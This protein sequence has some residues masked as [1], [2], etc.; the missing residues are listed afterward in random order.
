MS[1]VHISRQGF[2]TKTALPSVTR[3]RGPVPVTAGSTFVLTG[4]G[5]NGD[6]DIAPILDWSGQSQ[7]LFKGEVAH[8]V[9]FGPFTNDSG[10]SIQLNGFSHMSLPGPQ[11]LAFGTGDFTIEFFTRSKD[12]TKTTT[13]ALIYKVG[14]APSAN[15][16]DIRVQSNTIRAVLG[17]TDPAITGAT[18][19]NNIWY[20]IALVRIAGSTKLYVNGTQSGSTVADTRNYLVPDINSTGPMPLLFTD[21]NCQFS[22]NG[23]NAL[24]GWI[25]NFRIVKGTGVYSGNFSK[26]IANL[27]NTGA[28]SA[29]SYSSTT[30]V[31]ITFPSTDCQLLLANG[32][33]VNYYSDTSGQ[34]VGSPTAANVNAG[35]TGGGNNVQKSGISELTP[36]SGSPG[37]IYFQAGYDGFESQSNAIYTLGTGNFTMETWFRVPKV[38]VT[39]IIMGM[40][41]TFSS[42][43]YN[44]ASSR[45]EYQTGGTARIVST[46]GLPDTWIHVAAVRIS[47]ST[48]LYINGVQEGITYTDGQNNSGT[49]FYMGASTNFNSATQR[50]YMSDVRIIKGVGIYTGTF[51]PPT[52]RLANSGSGSAASYPSTT[53]INTSYASS[54]CS[55]LMS[56]ITPATILKAETEA[57]IFEPKPLY[58][59]RVTCDTTNFKTASGSM[60]FGNSAVNGSQIFVPGVYQVAA[61]TNATIEAW[62]KFNIYTGT[63]IMFAIGNNTTFTVGGFRVGVING[64][65]CRLNSNSGNDSTFGTLDVAKIN[66]WQHIAF[67]RIAALNTVRAYVDG[68]L[69]GSI[70]YAGTSLFGNAFGFYIGN[71]IPRDTNSGWPTFGFR[72]RIDSFRFVQNNALYVANFT[73]NTE[74]IVSNVSVYTA[75]TNSV[76]GLIQNI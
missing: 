30:N 44:A 74:E 67:V 50:W 21:L 63:Q 54:A 43:I 25:S 55:T 69:L 22:N 17:T 33:D 14:V 75:T 64:V 62:Y 59:N 29:A 5:T 15:Y 36:Y 53:N 56:F 49:R 1:K 45:F 40:G 13:I 68:V 58:V 10:Q 61:N 39:A 52:S 7:S 41:D 73:P 37:S 66:Q 71:A 9:N 60:D 19:S 4:N 28:G 11:S 31:N 24:Y 2:L 16:M 35:W 47:G 26:P 3:F 72:G 42:L 12:W 70:T 57:K 48:K 76:Y 38:M 20:H 8:M 32:N 34:A 23:G 51:T 6:G 46:A 18:L 27:Q 65:L